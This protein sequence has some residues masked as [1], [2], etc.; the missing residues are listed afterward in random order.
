MFWES[1]V[2]DLFSCLGIVMRCFWCVPKLRVSIAPSNLISS[3]PAENDPLG[4]FKQFLHHHVELSLLQLVVV[5]V[6]WLFLCLLNVCFWPSNLQ[7][8][9]Y[10]CVSTGHSSD[11][12][13]LFRWGK[14]YFKSHCSSQSEWPNQS[15]TTL[16]SKCLWRHRCVF[17][18]KKS[19]VCL[20][21]FNPGTGMILLPVMQHTCHQQFLMYRE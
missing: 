5:R 18:E 16:I 4:L 7:R 10:F 9:V 21:V 17:P 11:W 2:I 20:N 8:S 6:K 1:L 13:F 15:L 19:S 3:R 14:F 12:G